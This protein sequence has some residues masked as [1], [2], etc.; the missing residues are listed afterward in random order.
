MAL[1]D[2]PYQWIF[3]LVFISMTAVIGY[4]FVKYVIFTDDK[5]ETEDD[6]PEKATS[7]VAE[8][9]EPADEAAATEAREHSEEPPP[10]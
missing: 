6:A 7:E 2:L 1:F 8:R 9:V 5:D 10:K 4:F 3:P